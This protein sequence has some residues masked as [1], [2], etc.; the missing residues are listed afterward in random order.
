[1]RA[2]KKTITNYIPQFVGGEHSSVEFS[3]H[4]PFASLS[5]P[6]RKNYNF[7]FFFFF[8]FLL[9]H[10]I[11]IHMG[12][13]T[14]VNETIFFLLSTFSKNE[15]KKGRREFFSRWFPLRFFSAISFWFRMWAQ[16][17]CESVREKKMWRM[18]VRERAYRARGNLASIACEWFTKI[19]AHWLILFRILFAFFFSN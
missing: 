4:F 11:H 8:F 13:Q 1:M 14:H 2:K 12:W 19:Y 15:Q 17:K 7:F 10:Q 5:M 3:L 6:E 18:C 9:T 16:K